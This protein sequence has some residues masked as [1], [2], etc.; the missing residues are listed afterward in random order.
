MAFGHSFVR[1]PPDIEPPKMTFLAMA[2]LVTITT[3]QWRR[4]KFESGGTRP[5][6]SAKFFFCLAPPLF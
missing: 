5:A 1:P 2:L 6:R 3:T 4:N